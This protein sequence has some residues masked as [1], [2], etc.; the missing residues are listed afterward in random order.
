MVNFSWNGCIALPSQLILPCY[1]NMSCI[2][3]QMFPA[4][5][6]DTSEDYTS[7]V[8]WREPVQEVL[9]DISSTSTG[10]NSSPAKNGTVTEQANKK[11]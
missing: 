8:F 1:L 4:R 5:L 7:F 10:S 11:K 9:I 3:D 6:E 2:V